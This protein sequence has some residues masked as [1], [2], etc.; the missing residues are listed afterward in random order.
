MRNTDLHAFHVIDAIDRFIG[1]GKLPDPVI[2]RAENAYIMFLESFVEPISKLSVHRSAHV[3]AIFPD[4]GGFSDIGNGNPYRCKLSRS[5]ST[6]V[7]Q[8]VLNSFHQIPGTTK[9]TA[10]ISFNLHPS[11]GFFVNVGD[12]PVHHLS[13]QRFRGVHRT[14]FDHDCLLLSH[15]L[16]KNRRACHAENH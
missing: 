14:P 16:G 9:G 8:A 13:R 11:L 15:G 4:V 10:G 2:E 7:H 1:G 5:L 12:D 6:H 3:G